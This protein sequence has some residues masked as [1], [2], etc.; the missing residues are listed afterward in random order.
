MFQVPYS[1]IIISLHMN[2]I[3]ALIYPTITPGGSDHRK[4][5]AL[6]KSHSVATRCV[7]MLALCSVTPKVLCLQ[8]WG[9][10]RVRSALCLSNIPGGN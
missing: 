1:K 10:E 7:T 6:C 3:S 5:M 4:L 9:Y 2:N 8:L